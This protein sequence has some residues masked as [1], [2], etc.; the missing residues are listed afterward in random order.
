ME[1][2]CEP[3]HQERS[4]PGKA[5]SGLFI[6]TGKCCQRSTRPLTRYYCSVTSLRL[7]DI[8][9]TVMMTN[10]KATRRR[11][12]NTVEEHADCSG[13][14]SVGVQGPVATRLWML[15]RRISV[16]MRLMCSP[17]T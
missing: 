2:G 16:R 8:V 6:E 11:G 5:L 14:H 9:W 3:S 12:G 10:D 17:L 7:R 4:D 15:N 13:S 1:A